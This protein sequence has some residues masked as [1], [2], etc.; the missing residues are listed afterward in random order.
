MVTD[1]A[2]WQFVTSE[3]IKCELKSS[4]RCIVCCSHSVNSLQTKSNWLTCRHIFASATCCMHMVCCAWQSQNVQNLVCVCVRDKLPMCKN[5]RHV[6]MMTFT[7]N[8]ISITSAASSSPAS[9][10]FMS[11]WIL[12]FRDNNG[13]VCVCARTNF[14]IIMHECDFK[15]SSIIGI[16]NLMPMQSTHWSQNVYLFHALKKLHRILNESHTLTHTHSY[17]CTSVNFICLNIRSHTI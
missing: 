14:D 9:H 15:R 13:R 5:E 2:Y 1:I 16:F 10:P 12:Y 6:I 4:S 3:S 11:S 7:V 8:H 17:R